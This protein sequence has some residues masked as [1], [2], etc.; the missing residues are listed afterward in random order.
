METEQ[1]SST[2][3]KILFTVDEAATRLQ[4]SPTWIYERTRRKAIP[5]R[6]LGKYVRFTDDDIR[7]IV[8]AV[9]VGKIA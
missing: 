4:V 1:Q 9:A 8:D 6:K 2:I 7:S 3:R 5:F